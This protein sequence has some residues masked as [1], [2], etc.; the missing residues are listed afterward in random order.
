MCVF[1]V[2]VCMCV[3]LSLSLLRRGGALS[4]EKFPLPDLQFLLHYAKGSEYLI[5]IQTPTS[6]FLLLSWSCFFCV[7]LSLHWGGEAQILILERETEGGTEAG[8]P[9]GRERH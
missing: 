3:Q 7:I 4:L 1:S 6:F 2:C 8:R 9:G 5:Q